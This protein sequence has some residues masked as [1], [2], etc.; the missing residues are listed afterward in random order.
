MRNEAKEDISRNKTIAMVLHK[1]S[2]AEN[3]FDRILNIDSGIIKEI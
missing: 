2:H 1:K 3:F